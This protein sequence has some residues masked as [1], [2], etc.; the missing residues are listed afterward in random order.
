MKREGKIG[1]P[2]NGC[3]FD[4]LISA[5]N[6]LTSRV[7]FLDFVPLLFEWIWAAFFLIRWLFAALGDRPFDVKKCE[8]PFHPQK[9]D[10]DFIVDFYCAALQLV[11]EI[12]GK[13]HFTEQRKPDDA[14]RTGIL[15]G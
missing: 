13:S 10:I 1:L 5:N 8:R 6:F 14:E 7:E 4:Y 15:E 2:F 12:D 9:N 3:I 11:I